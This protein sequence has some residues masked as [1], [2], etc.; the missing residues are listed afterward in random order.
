ML[1]GTITFCLS[2]EQR[3]KVL[4]YVEE[5]RKTLAAFRRIPQSFQ[6]MV[7]EF[8]KKVQS[9]V[10]E[11]ERFVAVIGDNS[12]VYPVTVQNALILSVTGE[13]GHGSMIFRQ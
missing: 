12:D 10:E 1:D 4:R 5:Y 8:E 3:E 11:L 7:G 13:G 9:N 6:E 2:D